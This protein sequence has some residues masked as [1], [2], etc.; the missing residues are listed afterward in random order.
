MFALRRTFRKFCLRK[1][2]SIE[3]GGSKTAPYKAAAPRALPACTVRK[4]LY[5]LPVVR[6]V[7]GRWQC[8]KFRLAVLRAVNERIPLAK[9]VIEKGG[10]P[11]GTSYDCSFS[12]MIA[13]G[14]S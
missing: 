3:N 4:L 1:T 5:A 2:N 14:Q 8:S 10:A 7:N 9:V 13:R 11:G 12:V 6:A